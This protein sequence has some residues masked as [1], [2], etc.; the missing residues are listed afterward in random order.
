NGSNTGA[1]NGNNNAN[2]AAGTKTNG[3]GKLP[4]TG[5]LGAPAIGCALVAAAVALGAGMYLR[6]RRG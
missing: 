3:K 2:K 5:D 1:N 4:K 6:R